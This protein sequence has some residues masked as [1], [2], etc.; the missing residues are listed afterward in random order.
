[1]QSITFITWNQNKADYLAK[2]LWMEVLHEK[3]ELDEIQSLNLGEVVEHKV[4]Q[5]Y[6]IAKKPILVEDTALEFSA[7]GKLPGTFI[8]FFVQELGHEWL[9]RLLDGR[10]RSA[11]AR[12]KYAYFDGTHLEIFTGELRGT[13]AE[14]PGFDNGFAWD[15][16]LIPE[17]FDCIRSELGEEDYKVT[18]L[19]VKPIEAVRDFLLKI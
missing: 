2:Y 11:I 15:R 19:K 16:I 18:Y 8:K 12:T 10:D 17:W 1:M 7:L 14:H 13:I 6:A 5:A 9:C 3:I 4:R